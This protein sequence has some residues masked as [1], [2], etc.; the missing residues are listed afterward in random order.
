[1]STVKRLFG[2]SA[3]FFHIPPSA[4]QKGDTVREIPRSQS[5][6]GDKK[7]ENQRLLN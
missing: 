6:A 7:A 3:E 4:V 5:A 1:M 2:I